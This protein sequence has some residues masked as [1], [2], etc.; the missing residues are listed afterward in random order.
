MPGDKKKYPT[1]GMN[2]LAEERPDVAK[3][4]MGYKDGGRMKKMGGGSAMYSRGYGVDKKSKRK[5]TELMDRG[6]MKKGEI[7]KNTKTG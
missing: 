7:K 2:A 1:E 6:G 5:P 4:I 3:K